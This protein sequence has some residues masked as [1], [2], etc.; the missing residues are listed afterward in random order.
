MGKGVGVQPQGAAECV[1]HLGRGVALAPLFQAGVVVRVH[2]GQD[3]DLFPAQPGH[4]AYAVA[5]HADVL[6]LQTRPACAEELSQVVVG[7]RP[8]LGPGGDVL[9]GCG[10][11][12]QHT[13]WRV[14]R[15]LL[16]LGGTG[17]TRTEKKECP[18]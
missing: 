10:A 9:P 1:E 4:L 11:P 7:H 12:R 13:S 6:R 17:Q 8:R 15:D 16:R 2:P 5:R 18:A 3:G 14:G